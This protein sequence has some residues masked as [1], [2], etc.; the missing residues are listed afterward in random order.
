M[1]GATGRLFA[2]AAAAVFLLSASAANAF[3]DL[4]TLTLNGG[5]TAT[6]ND[7]NLGNGAGGEA[8]SAFEPTPINSHDTI[9]GSFDF[10]LV[11]AGAT[12]QAD[13]IALVFQ[14]DPNG[15]HALGSGGGNIGADGIQNGLG[16]G[17]QSWTNN[18]ATIFQTSDPCGVYCGT[19]PLGNFLL[20]GNARND[21]SVTFSYSGG[22][23]SYSAFNSDTS[24]SITDSLA[25]NLA[26]FGPSVYLGFTGG[27]GLSYAF[28]D[29]S[30]FSVSAV[31]EPSTWAMLL[32]GFAVLGFTGYRRA[33]V[34]LPLVKAT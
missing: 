33:K 25:F 20:G 4:T 3:V 24:Q 11:N 22:V 27:S 17:F 29:V 30:N 8:M 31:P 15:A 32:L 19:Q 7:L 34:R 14:N 1:V 5:A 23:L 12:P 21:V 28:Q 26:T 18:H 13:G 6:A 16:I 9:T 10:T 2:G